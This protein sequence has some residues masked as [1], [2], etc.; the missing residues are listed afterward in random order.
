MTRHVDHTIANWRRFQV[1]NHEREGAVS[2][3]VAGKTCRPTDATTIKLP[4]RPI[5]AIDAELG[6]DGQTSL[7]TLGIEI[8]FNREWRAGARIRRSN[9]KTRAVKR[10]A[11]V[12]I[13]RPRC[14]NPQHVVRLTS[15]RWATRTW[16]PLASSGRQSA[17]ERSG[18]PSPTA[19]PAARHTARPKCRRGGSGRRIRSHAAADFW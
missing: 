14:D 15:H 3:S 9:R 12:S 16:Q 1:A 8:A 4:D 6:R 10:S 17:P 19:R 5:Y 2:V 11:R 7:R 13:P 18:T